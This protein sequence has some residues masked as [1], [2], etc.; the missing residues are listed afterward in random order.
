ML[1][2]VL[3][4]AIREEMVFFREKGKVLMRFISINF[5]K[6][7]VLFMICGAIAG[8]VLAYLIFFFEE[9][10]GIEGSALVPVPGAEA[11]KG[12]LNKQPH[13]FT[14]I[15][16]FIIHSGLAVSLGLAAY[17]TLRLHIEPKF[18]LKKG[19]VIVSIILV[20]AM[21]FVS[22]CSYIFLFNAGNYFTWPKLPLNHM[23]AKVILLLAISILSASI[24]VL[25]LIFIGCY[26]RKLVSAPIS[27]DSIEI[28]NQLKDLIERFLLIIGLI[29]SVGIVTVYFFH[30][31]VMSL[32][33][34]NQMGPH[35]VA[36]FGLLFTIFIAISFIPT[37]LLLLEY[38]KKQTGFADSGF[39]RYD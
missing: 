20:L 34:D 29:L 33:Q 18:P 6:N 25:G 38:G 1:A 7:P 31:A 24:G 27:E 14:W 15:M 26:C 39:C 13:F 21:V 11:T 12:I 17:Q 19:E 4:F 3:K 5:F 37:R 16:L 23:W 35:G 2:A 28:Y 8:F 32:K 10:P 9:L 22:S 30:A 36:I